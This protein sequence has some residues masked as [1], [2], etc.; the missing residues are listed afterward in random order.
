MPRACACAMCR[1]SGYLH[2]LEM[3]KPGYGS[4]LARISMLAD[5]GGA[6]L[7]SLGGE[8]S[9]VVRQWEFHTYSQLVADTSSA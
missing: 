4:R 3:V 6:S 9:E 2:E 5:C 1:A 8:T 7:S